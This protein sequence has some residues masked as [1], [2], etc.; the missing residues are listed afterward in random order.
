M[1]VLDCIIPIEAIPGMFL[2]EQVD[3]LREAWRCSSGDGG[4]VW[5]WVMKK[6]AGCSLFSALTLTAELAFLYLPL[7]RSHT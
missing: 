4:W 1:D 2:N 7:V 3:W 5:E 6:G